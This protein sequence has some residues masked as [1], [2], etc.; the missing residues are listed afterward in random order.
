MRPS[1]KNG[2]TPNRLTTTT[3]T[4]INTSTFGYSYDGNDNILVNNESGSPLSLVY[5]PANRKTT[6]ISASGSFTFTF[7][8]NGN[9]TGVSDSTGLTTLAYDKENRL[10]TQAQPDGTSATYGYQPD[11]MKRIELVSGTLTTLVWDGSN[12]LEGRQ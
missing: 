8:P 3:I 2:T 12:Y 7:C 10:S 9:L 11:N 1:T 6:G 5:D 4:G